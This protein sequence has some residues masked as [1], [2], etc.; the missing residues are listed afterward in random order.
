[1]GEALIVRRGGGGGG[2]PTTSTDISNS[3][4]WNGGKVYE[5]NDAVCVIDL[6]KMYLA[7][8]RSKDNETG[9]SRVGAIVV[10]NGKII[11]DAGGAEC[12]YGVSTTKSWIY[13]NEGQWAH[14][15][16]MFVHLLE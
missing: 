7:L 14:V 6:N 16:D 8:I 13:A 11:C 5:Y 2:M 12:E 3:I 4:K 1:M 15:A 10:S 9:D